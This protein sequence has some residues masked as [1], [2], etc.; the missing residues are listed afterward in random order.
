MPLA[1]LP[2]LTLS[3]SAM[4]VLESAP[5]VTFVGSAEDS[6]DGAVPRLHAGDCN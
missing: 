3:S 6:F 5:S 1:E 4:D 2:D